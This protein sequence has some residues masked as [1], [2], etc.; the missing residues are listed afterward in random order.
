MKRID[1]EKRA[2]IAQL[3]REGVGVA[4]VMRRTHIC[5]STF[6][7]I[8]DEVDPFFQREEG[9]EYC[10]KVSAS[11]PERWET[12]RERLLKA[13]GRANDAIPDALLEEWGAVTTKVRESLAREA[14][15]MEH[16]C[17]GSKDTDGVDDPSTQ[18]I[19]QRETVVPALSQ[20]GTSKQAKGG[21]TDAEKGREADAR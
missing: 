11:F 9:S 4:E 2:Y 19:P 6:Y 15:R 1:A 10:S 3:I 20:P 13:C 16:G 7:N 5:A 18:R 21:D 17:F 12:A 8:R 14:F